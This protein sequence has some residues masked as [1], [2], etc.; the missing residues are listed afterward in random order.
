MLT[1]E[2]KRSLLLV[3]DFRLRLMAAIHEGETAVR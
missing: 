1:I 2:P 3:V